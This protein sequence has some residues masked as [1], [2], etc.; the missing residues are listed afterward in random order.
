MHI[1]VIVTMVISW[2]DNNSQEILLTEVFLTEAVY[3]T[4]E[5]ECNFFAEP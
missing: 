3:L 4:L 1:I 2:S 5:V